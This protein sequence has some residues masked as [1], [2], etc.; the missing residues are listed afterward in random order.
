MKWQV[1]VCGKL[2]WTRSDCYNGVTSVRIINE[3]TVAAKQRQAAIAVWNRCNRDKKSL[4]AE[5]LKADFVKKLTDRVEAEVRKLDYCARSDYE[6]VAA[7]LQLGSLEQQRLYAVMEEAYLW[8]SMWTICSA[9][10][11]SV[12]RRRCW[13]CRARRSRRR[14]PLP[15]SCN[16]SPRSSDCRVLAPRSTTS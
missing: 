5:C 8:R 16:A 14:S 2:T 15:T 3:N 6:D 11:R 7:C 12:R 1:E 13:S 10:S 9:G 4:D